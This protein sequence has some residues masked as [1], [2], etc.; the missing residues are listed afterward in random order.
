[1][2]ALSVAPARLTPQLTASRQDTPFQ[3]LPNRNRAAMRF[4]VEPAVARPAPPQIRT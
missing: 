1:M 4:R 3:L 2:R